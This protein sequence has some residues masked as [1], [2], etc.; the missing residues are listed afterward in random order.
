VNRRRQILIA[1]GAGALAMSH[2]ALAQPKASKIPHIGYL[3]LGSDAS[4]G[5][6][7]NAFKD[8]LRE[9][10]YVE[11][12]NIAIDVT[13][14]G[15]AAYEFPNLAAALVKTNPAAI[16]TTCVPSTKAAKSA[17][18]FIPVVMSVDGDPVA[19]GLVASLAR[20]GAN[21]T[22][23]STLFEELIPKHLEFLKLAVPKVRN[24]AVLVNPEGLTTPYFLNKFGEA[25]R[26]IGVKLISAEASVPADFEPAFA[27]MKKQHA[28]AFVVLTEA[29]MAG[30]LQRIVTLANVYKLPGIYGFREFAEAG[31]LMSYGLSYKDYY[32]EVARYVD[33]VLKGVKPA[34]LP[35]EQPTKIELVINQSTA[36]TLGVTLP[37]QL[38]ARADKVIE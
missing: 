17:T 6:F 13:W 25:A 15:Q 5:A 31:G 2:Q 1:L 10:A 34:D 8:A 33:K 3:S 24:I 11:G 18:Q 7:L 32:K 29:F 30:Q 14:A 36:K 20:P 37:G 22:G 26:Q 28:D 19:S 23:T 9:L 38:L 27:K 4:N 16:V 21:V 12:R 35:I